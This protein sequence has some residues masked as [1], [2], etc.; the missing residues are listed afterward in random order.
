MKNERIRVRFFTGFLGVFLAFHFQSCPILAEIPQIADALGQIPAP[1]KP[2]VSIQNPVTEGED[3]GEAMLSNTLKSLPANGGREPKKS[4]SEMGDA[5]ETMLNNALKSLPT[6]GGQE[7]KNL[8]GIDKLADDI[9]SKGMDSAGPYR[10]PDSDLEKISGMHLFTEEIFGGNAGK[11]GPKAFLEQLLDSTPLDV[12]MEDGDDE[13]NEE[14]EEELNIN[15]DTSVPLIFVHQM[16]RNMLPTY[17]A[18]IFASAGEKTL[19]RVFLDDVSNPT[20][21]P[22]LVNKYLSPLLASYIKRENNGPAIL[23]QLYYL[24]PTLLSEG[25]PMDE[26]V[27]FTRQPEGP[28]GN[29][30]GGGGGGPPSH[31]LGIDVEKNILPIG[32]LGLVILLVLYISYKQLLL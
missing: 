31:F 6:S 20:N 13:E 1:A 10:D 11:E 8:S 30:F 14:D 15:S 2:P 16:P 22:E 29:V 28:L 5:A 23:F 32:F 19:I 3:A 7:G 24:N 4:P 27:I 26:Y 25:M 21:F 17:E 18:Y 9:L 12:L